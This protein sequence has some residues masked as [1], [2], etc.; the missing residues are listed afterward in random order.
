MPRSRTKRTIAL[1]AL[2]LLGV[3]GALGLVAW[4]KLARSEPVRFGDPAEQFKYGPIGNMDSQGMPY[5][6]WLVLPRVFGEYLPGNGGYASFG[7]KSEGAHEVPVGFARQTIGFPRVSFN[8]ALCHSASYRT[9]AEG[10]P[11][12][13]P[14]GPGH[15]QN[16]QA[17]LQFLFQCASDPRFN[18]DLLLAEIKQNFSLS[19]IDE[20]LYRH[21]LIPATR[22]ALL[23]Q[24][25]ANEW[26]QTRPA[27][28]PG[29]IDPFNSVKIGLLGM[30]VDDTIGNADNMPIWFLRSREGQRLHW[31]GM[32]DSIHEVM[33]TSALG[34]GATLDSLP[35]PELA[36]LEAWLREVKPPAYPG[37][38]DTALAQ[39][40]KAVFDRLCHDCHGQGG[41]V[42]GG[43]VP[44]AEV[45]TDGQ[46]HRLWNQ[47]AADRYNAYAEN[48]PFDFDRWVAT[49]GPRDGYS[50][51]PLTG[52]WLRAPYLHNGSVPSL[53]DLLAEPYGDDLPPEV[54]AL[55]TSLAELPPRLLRTR[56]AELSIV[57]EHVR[58]AR[59]AGRRPSVFFRGYDL[60]D[61][62]HVG[63]VSDR[64]SIGEEPQP[65]LFDTRLP[66][67]GQ[68]GHAGE[69]Y[70]TTLP[71]DEKTALIE[72]LKTL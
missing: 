60:V 8:C 25:R 54:Q 50:S 32:N 17:Y 43:V 5:Y 63:F 4:S 57:Q 6:V 41:K 69:R 59:A 61:F 44:L 55:S 36:V 33:L 46:R 49:D 7:F 26:M 18:A 24:K 22:T 45:G 2:S 16:T 71:P 14:A 56:S 72:Y 29:R 13:V 30:R 67:N 51:T 19:F 31:D 9:S 65:F 38:I 27:W 42:T 21:V 11:T 34:D 62:E 28:G 47:D 35:L 66:G 39:R 52:L 58:A 23:A 64:G 53:A 15:T 3:A 40:G 1:I 37:P 12:I 10:V 68:G 20:L 70:G 48:Y